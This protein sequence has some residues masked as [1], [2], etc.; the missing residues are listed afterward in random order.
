MKK[1]TLI[2]AALALVAG[3]SGAFAK[4]PE[5]VTTDAPPG[6]ARLPSAIYDARPIGLGDLRWREWPV[7]IPYS[8]RETEPTTEPIYRCTAI[9]CE[10][11]TPVHVDVPVQTRTSPAAPCLSIDAGRCDDEKR[12]HMITF[13]KSG[14]C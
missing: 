7:E 2:A 3:A 11:G 9:G 5:S 6:Y 8:S 12:E 10:S 1:H 4:E 13:C 14:P